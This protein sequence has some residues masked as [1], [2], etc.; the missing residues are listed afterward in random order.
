MPE[1]ITILEYCGVKSLLWFHTPT[2]VCAASQSKMISDFGSW[3]ERTAAL[4][5]MGQKYK[6][7]LM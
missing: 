7:L 5:L 3:S 2:S 1:L 6:L 4:V